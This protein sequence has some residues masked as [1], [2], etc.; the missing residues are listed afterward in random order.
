MFRYADDISFLAR[1]PGFGAGGCNV[2]FCFCRRCVKTVRL[3]AV[4]EGEEV[5]AVAVAVAVVEEAL[6]VGVAAI[7]GATAG[8]R[9]V[10]EGAAV[11]VAVTPARCSWATSRGGQRTTTFLLPSRYGGEGVCGRQV[12]TSRNYWYVKTSWYEKMAC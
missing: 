7:M 11:V 5:A 2:I 1:I 6:E 4:G 8:G 3:V 9:V 10:G 12:L